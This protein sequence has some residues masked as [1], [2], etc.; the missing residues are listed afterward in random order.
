[1]L[2][3]ANIQAGCKIKIV[4]PSDLNGDGQFDFVLARMCDT[5]QS[6]LIYI[7]A[8]FVGKLT[9]VIIVP[10]MTFLNQFNYFGGVNVQ[11]YLIN[12]D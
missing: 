4:W 11:L 6:K 1:M 9:F 8:L 12:S 10:T 5:T 3:S 7:M 2:Q